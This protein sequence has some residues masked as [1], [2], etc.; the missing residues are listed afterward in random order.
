MIIKWRLLVI[1]MALIT[2]TFADCMP[3]EPNHNGI[4]PFL[5]PS[6]NWKLS[7]SIPNSWW[8]AIYNST[9]NPS[10]SV[11]DDTGG[12]FYKYLRLLSLTPANNNL[13]YWHL[14]PTR[15]VLRRMHSNQLSLPATA[16]L[17]L[18]FPGGPRT[19]TD[20]HGGLG[21]SSDEYLLVLWIIKRVNYENPATDKWVWNQISRFLLRFVL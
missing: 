5:H 7:S 12:H 10:H 3:R 21:L 17:V 18:S 20:R 15:V 16:H 2:N 13:C 14:F 1:F 11:V 9:L 4:S 6:P 8:L 19:E